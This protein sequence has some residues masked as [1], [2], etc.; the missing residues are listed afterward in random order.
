MRHNAAPAGVELE[1]MNNG[2]VTPSS[3]TDAAYTPPRLAAA[4]A[5]AAEQQQQQQ[6]AAAGTAT[7]SGPAGRPLRVIRAPERLINSAIGAADRD[8]HDMV[9]CEQYSSAPA[10]SGQPGAQPFKV[11]VAPL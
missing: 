7:P 10:G 11:L 8:D 4:A 6:E 5:T 3:T 2:T 9:R 1:A